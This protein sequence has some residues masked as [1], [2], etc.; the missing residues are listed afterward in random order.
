MIRLWTVAVSVLA[1]VTVSAGCGSTTTTLAPTTASQPPAYTVH[2]KVGAAE[3]YHPTRPGAH[4]GA[5]TFTV[6][7]VRHSVPCVGG[8]VAEQPANGQWL[9]VSMTWTTGNDP[10]ALSGLLA[11]RPVDF[12]VTTDRVTLRGTQLATANAAGC[13]PIGDTFTLT[14]T[15]VV[16]DMTYQGEVILDT[17][18]LGAG[19]TVTYRLGDTAYVYGL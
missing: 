2:A 4:T 7:A 14:A 10:A 19:S 3:I 9:G 12:S 18:P 1:A 15:P 17:R 8:P 6:T 5:V 16:P 11:P 13:L